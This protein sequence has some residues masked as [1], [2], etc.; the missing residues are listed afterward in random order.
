MEG[1]FDMPR[2]RLWAE[3]VDEPDTFTDAEMRAPAKVVFESTKD[4]IDRVGRRLAERRQGRRPVEDVAYVSFESLD[5][6]LAVLTPRRNEILQTVITHGRFDSIDA[7]A[8]R[9]YRD[10]AAVSR[11]LKVLSE[12]GLVFVKQAVLPGHGRRS[13]I[14]VIAKQLNLEVTL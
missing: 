7:L 13:E 9:L 11:D 4:V 10:R 3:P 5:A 8:Q 14:S 2:K 12:S 1:T 6:L